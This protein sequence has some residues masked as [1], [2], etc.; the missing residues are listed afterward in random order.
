MQAE[1]GGKKLFPMVLGDQVVSFL[2]Q[3]RVTEALAI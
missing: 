3:H 2:M 1:E